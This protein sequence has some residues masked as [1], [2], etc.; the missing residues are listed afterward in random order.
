MV[1]HGLAVVSGGHKHTGISYSLI[2]RHDVGNILRLF[3]SRLVIRAVTQRVTV[4]GMVDQSL[5]TRLRERAS[6]PACI[7]LQFDL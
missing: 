3:Y 2:F 4:M 6:T 5:A 1:W 7:D